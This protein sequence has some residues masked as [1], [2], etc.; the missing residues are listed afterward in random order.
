MFEF[1]FKYPFAAYRK[2]ELLFASGWPVWL[3]ATL[4]TLAAVGLFW[5]MHR[6]KSRLRG[7]ALWVVWALQCLTGVLVLVLLWQPALAIQSLKNRQNAVAV[8]L[9][10]SRS[11]ALGEDG[12]SRLAQ[13]AAELANRVL[14]ALE[15]RFQVRLYSF[16]TSPERMRSL[17]PEH[18]PGPGAS[19]GIGESVL[20]VLRESTVVPLGAVLVASDGT[21]NTGR[22]GRE[23][24][25]AIRKFHVPV[26]TIGVGRDRIVGDV[27]LAELNVAAKAMPHSRVSAQLT[28]LHDGQEERA[29]RLTVR[30]GSSVLASQPLTLRRGELVRREWIEFGAGDSG[31]RDLTFTVEPLAGEEIVENNA[32]SHILD[33]P[34]RRRRILYAEGE[35][36]WQYKFMRRAV[37]KDASVQLVTLL[38]TSANKFYRQGVDTPDEL[39]GGFPDRAEELFAFDALIVG[40][41][42]AAFFTP[43]Q[44]AAIRDFVSRR[45]GTLM[46][47]AGRNGLGAG[48]WQY[49][50]IVDVLPA[51]LPP[52]KDSFIR[53][54]VKV[55]LTPQGRNSLVCRLDPDPQK[56]ATLWQEMPPLADYQRLGAL[57]PAAVPLLSL[58][59]GRNSLPLLVRQHYGRGRAVIFATGGSWTWKMGLPSD[60]TRHHTFWRQLL[61]SLVVHTPGMV[62]ITSDRSNYADESRVR[63][64]AEVRTEDYEFANHAE[65]SAVVTAENGLPLPVELHPSPSE[66]GVYE[67]EFAAES[68]GVYRIEATA[69]LGGRRLGADTLHLLRQG[70]IA[71]FFH[72]HRNAGLL[73]RLA[74]QTGGRY[75]ELDELDQLPAEIGFSEAGIT[76]REVLDLWDMPALF[77][78]VLLL[79]A[80]EWLLRKKGGVI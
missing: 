7:R 33:V 55:E 51:E 14:P 8:L 53:E 21:D 12:L 50:E 56:N 44:Q 60:D 36:R 45:G 46:M 15:E 66:Q 61:R 17:Q 20:G 47:L 16:A 39:E 10:T 67:A 80:G 24:M 65:V 1:L 41:F 37:H 72:P 58:R 79:R 75:W 62:R 76:T 19:S 26:H 38:R 69:H 68:L 71:E 23:T 3:L 27:E 73:V 74:E 42:E 59:D 31:V 11:M 78:L 29:T 4:A 35:P 32:R 30:D 28:I 64:R 77:L 54:K 48:G 34:R 13:A 52:G 18:L 43:R 70:G 6:G 9:D 49:S 57:K 22:F 2:G 63:L 25:A 5:H 40:S